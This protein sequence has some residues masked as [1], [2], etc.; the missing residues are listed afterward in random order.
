MT[1]DRSI[2]RHTFPSCS[3]PH[4]L[5]RCRGRST[6]AG[7]GGEETYVS[8]RLSASL[9]KPHVRTDTGADDESYYTLS[10]LEFGR[11]GLRD[12][13]SAHTPSGSDLSLSLSLS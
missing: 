2:D 3:S 7:A 10:L 6:T 12:D 13:V 11:G 5:H 8:V 4:H 1:L 9:G